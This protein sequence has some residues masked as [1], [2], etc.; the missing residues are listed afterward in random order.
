MNSISTRVAIIVLAVMSLAVVLAPSSGARPAPLRHFTGDDDLIVG[1][2]AIVIGQVA[3]LA[4]RLDREQDRVFTYITVEVE[5]TLK[6][7]VGSGRIVLKEEGGDVGDQGSVVWG[8]PRFSRG[9]RVL[10]Y[11]DTWADGSL[12]VHEMSYGKLSVVTDESGNR[13]IVRDDTGCEMAPAAANPS[14]S[15]N[16]TANSASGRA[17]R[18]S[19][20]LT[21]DPINLDDY[22]GM[23]RERLAAN[24]DRAQAFEARYYRDVPLLAQP[25]EYGRA[26]TAGEIRPQFV[27]LF[28]AKSVRWW[29]PDS[30]QPVVFFVNPDGAPN[31]AVVDDVGAAMAAWSNLPGSTLRIVNGGAAGVCGSQRTVNAM[32]FNNCDNRFS[33]SPDCARV[34]ALGGLKWTSDDTKQVNGQTYVRAAYGFVSF[35]PYSACSYDDHCSLRE[36]ATHELGHALGLGHSQFPDATMSGTAHFDGRCASITDDDANGLAFIYPVNDLGARPLAIDTP[37]VLPDAINQIRYATVLIAS[38]GTMGYTW[39]QFFGH[40]PSG[41]DMNSLGTI[42]GIPS[43]TGTFSFLT[44]VT[45][46]AGNSLVKSFTITVRA[47]LQYDSRFVSQLPVPSLQAGQ[48]FS[49]SLKW[50]NLGSQGLDGTAGTKV[51]SQNPANNLTWG[52]AVFLVPGYTASGNQLETRLT[53]TAPRAPGTYNFQWQLFQDGRGFIGQPSANLSVVVTAG[54]PTID[55]SGP[56]QAVAGSPFTFQLT[57]VGGTAPF[58]WSIAAG[59]LPAGLN[60]NMQTG[61]ISGTPGTP[62]SATFTAQVADAASR[63]AQRALSITVSPAPPPQLALNLLSTIQGVKGT[64]LQ[65]QPSASGGTPPYTWS[66]TAGALPT[67]MT[68]NGTTGAISGTPSVSGDFTATVTVRDQLSQT[69]SGILSVRVTEPAAV[70][71]IRKVKYKPG[72]QQVTVIG[73]LIDPSATLTVDGSQVAARFESGNLIAKPAPL[74]AGTHEVRVVNPGGVSSLPFTLTVP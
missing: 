38:G 10:L 57:V 36:V 72:K 58:T 67:G 29:E 69:A 17:V 40:L 13:I 60:L 51:V 20:K 1:A 31:P 2:R 15:S 5:E 45:D 30:G 16:L 21:A 7:Q 39:S 71:V 52:T 3:T 11:L 6:G 22:T 53:L 37:T 70:P 73:D 55:S 42:A 44:Q 34:I 41:L 28:S 4:C 35:N 9:E 56:L 50:E 54:P 49:T 18:P 27:L 14:A 63:T 62:G 64:A 23:V 12:R 8:A 24:L 74:T 65:Y 61:L 32:T 33:P 26:I 48:I 43:E 47:P 59:A 68:I 19:R 66:I 25:A 46:S